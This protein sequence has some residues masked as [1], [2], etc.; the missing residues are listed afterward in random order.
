M[1]IAFQSMPRLKGVNG[2]STTCYYPWWSMGKMCASY[3]LSLVLCWSRGLKVFCLLVLM[4]F[5]FLAILEIKLQ[6]STTWARFWVL[7]CFHLFLREGLML[8]VWPDVIFCLLHSWDHRHVPPTCS[9]L[10]L[11]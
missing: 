1:R 3:S 9:L 10:F 2:N 5:F 11:N 6:I 8:L 7:F 4:L